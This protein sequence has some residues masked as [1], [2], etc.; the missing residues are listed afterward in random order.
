MLIALMDKLLSTAQLEYW[1]INPLQMNYFR[2][3]KLNIGT[4]YYAFFTYSDPGCYELTKKTKE[5]TT[6]TTIP[7]VDIM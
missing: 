6:E 1:N 7:T 5:P 2:C 3:T 4:Y